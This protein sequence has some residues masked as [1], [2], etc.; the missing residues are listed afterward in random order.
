MVSQ[1]LR[2]L[3]VHEQVVNILF[4][5]VFQHSGGEVNAD[6]S[7]RVWSQESATEPRSTT[8]VQHGE[9]LRRHEG[10]VLDHSRHERWRAVRQLLKL[11]FEARGK[12]VEGSR[13]EFIRSTRRYASTTAGRE[14]VDGNG[15]A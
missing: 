4:F 12:T 14:H 1:V 5:R 3:G 13:D 7:A 10:R 9:A 6:Q 8:G 2:Q 15:V 11:R